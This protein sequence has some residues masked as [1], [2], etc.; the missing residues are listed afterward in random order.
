MRD[1]AD[2]HLPWQTVA[3]FA[4]RGIVP[5]SRRSPGKKGHREDLEI[6]KKTPTFQTKEVALDPFLQVSI[7]AQTLHL[8]PARHA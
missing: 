1:P 2:F 3:S 7:A 6:E 5:L 8:G 4:R